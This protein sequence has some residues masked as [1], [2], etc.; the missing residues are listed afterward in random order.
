VVL[1]GDDRDVH[2]ARARLRGPCRDGIDFRLTLSPSPPLVAMMRDP[3]L[4]GRLR[5]PAGPAGRARAPRGRAH[6]GPARVPFAGAD[7][8]RPLHTDPGDLSPVRGQRPARLRALRG[9]RPAGLITC[10]VTDMF[11]PLADRNWAVCHVQVE[12]AA[13]EHERHFG[14]RPRGMWLAECGYLRGVDELLRNTTRTSSRPSRP[15][16]TWP[17]I[18][19]TRWRPPSS[20]RRGTRA[21]P[22]CG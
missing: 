7:V 21:A 11:L 17:A 2:S 15:A 5:Q 3:L 6:T 20:P 4:L 14:R 10:N 9:P 16:S 8:P 13:R 22:R 18:P 1:R 12:L 19:L